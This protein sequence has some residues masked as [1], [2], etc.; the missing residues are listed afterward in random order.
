MVF[1]AA[2]SWLEHFG[3]N[4]KND[5]LAAIAGYAELNEDVVRKAHRKGGVKLAAS[6]AA[7]RG[8]YLPWKCLP[9]PKAPKND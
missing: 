6:T 4:L 9:H 3:M 8:N 1:F 5:R 2:D 7:S